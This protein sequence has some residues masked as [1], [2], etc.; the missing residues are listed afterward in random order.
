M[1]QPA[2]AR[3]S[4]PEQQQQG[5]KELQERLPTPRMHPECPQQHTCLQLRSDSLA[6]ARALCL[7]LENWAFSSRTWSALAKWAHQV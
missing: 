3:S 6:P 5:T 7:R 1:V 4:T 2:Y